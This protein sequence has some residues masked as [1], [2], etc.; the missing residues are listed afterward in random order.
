MLA[1]YF[2]IILS[3]SIISGKFLSYPNNPSIGDTVVLKCMLNA[4][5]GMMFAS[6]APK[7]KINNS[8]YPISFDK[9]TEN[10]DND[11]YYGLHLPDEDRSRLRGDITIFFIKET[12][13]YTNFTCLAQLNN[14]SF[15]ELMLNISQSDSEQSIPNSPP[16][17]T[18][19]NCTTEEDAILKIITG[20]LSFVFSIKFSIFGVIIFC[21]ICYLAKRYYPKRTVV[22]EVIQDTK[23]KPGKETEDVVL[24]KFKPV[25][26]NATHEEVQ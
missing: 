16:T 3:I 13:L 24:T 21:V 19:S 14:D 22:P 7:L 18:T 6:I 10:L 15:I 5:E 23:L 2:L 4:P 25:D 20:L 1:T 8:G 12:D 9:I 26:G 17:N 11:R